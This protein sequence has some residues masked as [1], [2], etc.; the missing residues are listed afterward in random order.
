VERS[1]LRKEKE[2]RMEERRLKGDK[3]QG[4]GKREEEGRVL[5]SLGGWGSMPF[6]QP[7]ILNP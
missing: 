6:F 5:R 7:I 4:S 1:L 2:K 3:E